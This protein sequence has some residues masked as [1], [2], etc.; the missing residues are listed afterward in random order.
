MNRNNH[1]QIKANYIFQAIALFLLANLSNL[2]FQTTEDIK[3]NEYLAAM[4]EAVLIKPHDR[5]Y[6]W[7]KNEFTAF[8]HLGVNTFT[9][10]EWGTGFEDP[11]IFNPINLDTD[12]WCEEIKA[13]GMKMVI[14]TAKH[15]DGFCLW[16]TRYTEHSVASSDWLNGKGDVVKDL[17]KSCE[18]YGLKLG[19]YL[20]PADLYQIENLEGL[21]G[22][23]SKYSKRVIPRPIKGKPFRDKRTFSYIVDDYNEYFMNQLFELLTEYGLIHEVWFDGAHPKRKG[24]QKYTYN[25]WYELIRELVPEAVIFGKGPD[26]RWCGNEAG[27]T[28]ESEWSVIPIGGSKD[29]WTWPDMTDDDLGSISKINEVLNKN[30]FLHWNPAETNTSIRHGWFWRDEAQYVKSV[31]EILDIWYRSVGGNTVFLLN[32]PPNNKGLLAERDVEVLNKVGG[33]LENTFAENLAK[34]ASVSSISYKDDNYKPDNIIDG[35]LST[36]WMTPDLKM[37]GELEITLPKKKLFNR[38]VLQEQIQDYSQRISEFEIL[39]FIENRWE[40]ISK[41]TTIGYKHISRTEEIST[42]RI[43]IKILDSRM[44]PTINNFGLYYEEVRISNPV[45][46]RNKLGMVNIKCVSPGPIIKYTTDGSI[47][48]ENS[49]TYTKPIEM[50]EHGIVKAIA[51]HPT[52][53]LK[54]EIA[55]NKFDVCPE[56]WSIH[57]VSSEQADNNEQAYKSIDGDESTNWI[58]QWRP[59]TIK[60]PHSIA[61]N[62]GEEVT[63]KG[64][65][66]TPRKGIING[67]IKKYRFYV[68]ENGTDWVNVVSKEFDNIKNNPVKQFVR[69]LDNVKASYIKLEAL[70][71]INGNP[72]AS[73]AEI[74]I[75]T[76]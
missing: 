47:P 22:N 10:R 69:F 2:H 13:A 57:G 76:K 29:N 68:S 42:D 30:G 1:H 12:Q 37:N 72:W 38:I 27:K 41:G 49:D 56:K 7:Q 4:K 43:K 55:T 26:V 33:I 66:Y 63:L 73:A 58:T 23:G 11:K 32:I 61:V 75:I 15:H 16:P 74:G 18:K 48:N 36:C 59:S 5:Q 21:Y 64:F 50:K 31:E 8:I 19:I 14:I 20:S 65:S 46:S 35:N 52:K 71:E 62:L 54:S 34:G 40:K 25:Q 39:A 60:H 17:S 44:S 67:T 3:K 53:R 9:G 6:E 28:R 45:I 70:S 24:G 51:V